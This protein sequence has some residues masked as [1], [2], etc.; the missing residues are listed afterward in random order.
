MSS[1]VGDAQLVAG[2]AA[3]DESALAALYDRHGALMYALAFRILNDHEDAEEAVM[4]AF[5]QAW[6]G[7]RA[8]SAERGSV[9]SWLVVLAR[10]R[11]LDRL[12]AR[13]RRLQAEGRAASESDGA[14]AMA[15]PAAPADAGLD[16]PETGAKV[17]NALG[18]LPEAQRRCIELAYFEGLSQSE[19]AERLAEPLG[20]VK[21]RIRL[22]MGKLRDL[23]RPLARELSA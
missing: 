10:S 16:R 17:R 20:T 6:R 2:L 18:E 19:I 21:T 22:A 9:S 8:W 5:T 12:R 15:Q 13:K 7:A 3:G 4:T 11:A 23:L 14:P 1:Q